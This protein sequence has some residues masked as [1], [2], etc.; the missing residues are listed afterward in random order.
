MVRH[1]S[2]MLGELEITDVTKLP[3]GKAHDDELTLV[4]VAQIRCD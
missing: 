3:A 2:F 1:G 4:L